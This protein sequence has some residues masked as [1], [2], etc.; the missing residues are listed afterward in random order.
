MEWKLTKD[1]VPED[2]E[3]VVVYFPATHG[4][5]NA[6]LAYHNEDGWWGRR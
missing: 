5:E 3:V 4:Y 1:E 2:K 6:R